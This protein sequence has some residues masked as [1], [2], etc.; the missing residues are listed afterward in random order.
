[1]R[2][3]KLTLL[4]WATVLICSTSSDAQDL[5]RFVSG[6][7]SPAVTIKDTTTNEHGQ[8]YV[9]EIGGKRYLA[10]TV[11]HAQKLAADKQRAALT[12][13]ELR[14][15]EQEVARLNVAIHAAEQAAKISDLQAQLANERFTKAETIISDQKLLLAKAE[16]L[17]GRRGWLD[18]TL[19]NTY[20]SIGLKIVVPVANL[21]LA[22][23]KK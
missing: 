10:I 3:L 4:L 21:I 20:V 23:Q 1:M 5:T 11:E 2:K 7:Q 12:E 9:L 14:L 13:Q 16:A 19:D 17:I 8:E 15:R 22:K 6:P 18:K